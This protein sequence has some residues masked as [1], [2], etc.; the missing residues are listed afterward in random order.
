MGTRPS[1][2]PDLKPAVLDVLC[3]A[4][5]LVV[6][7]ILRHREEGHLASGPRANGSHGDHSLAATRGSRKGFQVDGT[8]WNGQQHY[9]LL[10]VSD[11]NASNPLLSKPP[12]DNVRQLLRVVLDSLELVVGQVG[13]LGLGG[14]TAP[15]QSA[16]HDHHKMGRGTVNRFCARGRLPW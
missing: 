13:E 10:S 5:F 2:A 12:G 11:G 8:R 6:E 15:R 9:W 4:K 3:G 1:K 16:P 7:S 14:G